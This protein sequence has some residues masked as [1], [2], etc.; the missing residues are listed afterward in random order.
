MSLFACSKCT[1]VE[2]TALGDYWRALM[3]HDPVLCSEC[4]TGKW[5]GL[6]PKRL[7]KDTDYVVRKDG[8]LEPP[9]G[10][11]KPGSAQPQ[12]STHSE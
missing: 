5:H 9:G 8:T 2:N 3:D 10:W 6:F 11:P 1:A 4:A 12:S 7:L